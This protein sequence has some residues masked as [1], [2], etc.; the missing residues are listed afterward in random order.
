M[1]TTQP[2]TTLYTGNLMF[3]STPGNPHMEFEQVQVT[4]KIISKQVICANQRKLMY[5]NYRRYVQHYNQQCEKRNVT[6]ANYNA[7][8]ETF[9]HQH[10]LKDDAKAATLDFQSSI[11]KVSIQEYNK[12]AEIENYNNG[13]FLIKM[14][15]YVPVR[16][17]TEHIFGMIIVKYATQIDKKN[18]ILERAGAITTRA[19]QKVQ[20]NAYEL[21]NTVINEVLT[22]PYCKRTV[23]NHIDRLCDAGILWDHTF[24][25][26]QK[27]VEYHVNSQIL[28]LFDAEKQKQINTDN[29]PFNF[30]IEKDLPNNNIVTRTNKDKR[31]INEIVDNQ[32]PLKEVLQSFVPHDDKNNYKNT[33]PPKDENLDAKRQTSGPEFCEI[34]ELL[35]KKVDHTSHLVTKLASGHYD[36]YRFTLRNHL[37]SEEMYGNMTKDEFLELV[38]QEFMKLTAPI[39]KSKNVYEGSWYNAI[40]DI[41]DLFLNPNR[42]IPT[43]KILMMRFDKLLWRITYAKRY[44][45]KFPDY[46]ILYPSEYFN[47]TRKDAASGGFAYTIEALK[48]ND[49][50]ENNRQKRKEK[51]NNEAAKRNN[52]N[53][54]VEL[55]RKKVQQMRKGKITIVEL[56]DYANN[57]AH[58]PLDIRNRLPQMIE[59][60][61]KC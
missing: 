57:N 17:P 6:V 49:E 61:Y 37:E 29:Q 21:A 41:T 23:Q 48:V 40:D 51:R 31:K 54:T 45:R 58:I 56:Y 3:T 7:K 19:I 13:R 44:K 26:S 33:K 27:P 35:R 46:Q 28:V 32:F 42:S 34:S 18:A 60:A 30:A 22:L 47:P 10:N 25:G 53:N 20:I 38:L 36:N 59:T 8:I 55:L 1:N 11:G 52:R 16:K 43:K 39:Y 15:K 12:A 4:P 24:R 5:D 14:K 50:K 9:I 2:R